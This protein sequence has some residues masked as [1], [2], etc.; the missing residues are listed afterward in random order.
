MRPPHFDATGTVLMGLVRAPEP[1]R[2]RRRKHLANVEVEI[3]GRDPEER[4]E[5]SLMACGVLFGSIDDLRATAEQLAPDDW[6]QHFLAQPTYPGLFLQAFEF[7]D[8]GT[9][10]VLFDFG[11]LDQLILDLHPDGRRAATVEP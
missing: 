2:R 10:R 1:E 9:T 6:R 4:A 5:S 3:H 11:D 7:H 8:S